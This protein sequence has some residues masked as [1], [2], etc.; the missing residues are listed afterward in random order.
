MSTDTKNG[1][2]IIMEFV[3]T[4]ML[5]G[6]INL[7]TVYYSDGKQEANPLLIILT[8]FAAI[9]FTRSISGGH[10][11][12]AV[13]LGVYFQKD[14]EERSKDQS[15]MTLYVLAQVLGAVCSCLFSYIFYRENVFKLTLNEN[16]TPG[17]GCLMEILAT[18]IFVYT[19]LCQGKIRLITVL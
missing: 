14:K 3:G 6:A 15:L 18:F 9:T 5:S 2:K 1:L 13:T 11:N 8:F 10:L 4:F 7:S 12:P 16:V 19:I 17:N